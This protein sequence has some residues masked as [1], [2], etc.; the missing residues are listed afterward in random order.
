MDKGACL[1]TVHGVTELD[2]TEATEQACTHLL[3]TSLI[4]V[5]TQ[6]CPME[7]SVMMVML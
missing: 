3:K 5:L 2:T 4:L 6:C 1:A 7:L